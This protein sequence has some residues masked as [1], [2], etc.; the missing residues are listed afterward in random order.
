MNLGVRV[1]WPGNIRSAS[2]TTEHATSS[3]GIPVLVMGGEALGP[4]DLPPDSKVL[5][6]WRKPRTGPVWALVDA[7]IKAGYPVEIEV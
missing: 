2:L 5:V 1:E 7:A 4:A 3:Y 6:V